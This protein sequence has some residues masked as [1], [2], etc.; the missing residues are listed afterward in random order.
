METREWFEQFQR[1]LEQRGEQRA[2]LQTVA[3]LFEK[4][5][6]RSLS[7]PERAALAER[8][9]RLG[10]DRVEDVVLSFS[11]EALGNWLA[12]PAAS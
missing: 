6:G 11:A 10:E 7:E 1:Q 8:L 4:R 2:R 12:D 5:L 9:D 3:R